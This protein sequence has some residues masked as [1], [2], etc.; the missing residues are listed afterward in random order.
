MPEERVFAQIESQ[1]YSQP[2]FRRPSPWIHCHAKSYIML[3]RHAR[4]EA[5]I[6]SLVQPSWRTRSRKSSEL[7]HLFKQY[8]PEYL[9][10]LLSTQ[11]SGPHHSSTPKRS[12]RTRMQHCD[13]CS[14]KELAA[15]LLTLL[16]SR[17]HSERS[18]CPK[19][20]SAG[21]RKSVSPRRVAERRCRP[22][23]PASSGESARARTLGPDW[24]GQNM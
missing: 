1:R 18:V 17:R 8:S 21:W 4:G 9:R 7:R 15:Y 14:F 22:L 2:S 3:E 12:R 24:I 11:A 5:T 23:L 19:A 10:S 20:N 6:K 16:T 13:R